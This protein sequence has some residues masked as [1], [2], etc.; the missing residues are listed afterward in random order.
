MYS[1]RK[2]GLLFNQYVD[3][4]DDEIFG[5]LMEA[6]DPI[7]DIVLKKYKKRERHFDDLKQEVKLKMWKN[8]RNPIKLGRYCK[9]PTTHMFYLIRSYVSIAHEKIKKIYEDNEKLSV[10]IRSEKWMRGNQ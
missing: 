6:I 10:S 7:I 5:E 8:Q 3:N 1:K 9:A 4:G 2:I